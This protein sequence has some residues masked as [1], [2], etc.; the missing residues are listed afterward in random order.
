[1]DIT[2]EIDLLR[3]KPVSLWRCVWWRGPPPLLTGTRGHVTAPRPVRLTRD[4][5]DA[6]QHVTS[7]AGEGD[8]VRVVEEPA[9]LGAVLGLPRGAAHGRCNT[10]EGGV[11]TQGVLRG[12]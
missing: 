3:V 9:V 7:E 1:M 8:V 11:S 5:L 10:W 2:C 4:R 6:V 12:S